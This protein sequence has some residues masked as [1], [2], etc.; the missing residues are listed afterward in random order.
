MTALPYDSPLLG[1]LIALGIAG[2]PDLETGSV[3]ADV[4]A[5]GRFLRWLMSCWERSSG[6]AKRKFVSPRAAPGPPSH[7]SHDELVAMA[8]T[9][10]ESR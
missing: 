5:A 2:A 4:F 3:A 9:R 1:G 6:A 10:S 8:R 7:G